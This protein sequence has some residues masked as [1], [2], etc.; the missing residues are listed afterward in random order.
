MKF[1]RTAV[2]FILCFL[3]IAA[4]YFLGA[5][6]QTQK[7]QQFAAET[8]VKSFGWQIDPS[9]P[10]DSFRLSAQNF[11]DECFHIS[12]ADAVWPPD[13]ERASR[14]V[15]NGI[16]PAILRTDFRAQSGQEVSVFEIPVVFPM[17]EPPMMATT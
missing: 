4:S 12:G 1:F 2:V 15:I 9:K 14:V 7:N 6:A 10:I 5:R 16:S 8:L 11:R 17:P 13:T 3:C